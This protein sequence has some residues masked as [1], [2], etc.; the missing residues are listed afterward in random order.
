[1]RGYSPRFTRAIHS[2]KIGWFGSIARARSSSASALSWRFAAKYTRASVRRHLALP[3]ARATACLASLLAFRGSPP[4]SRG[5]LSRQRNVVFDLLVARLNHALLIAALQLLSRARRLAH[6]GR[7]LR[8][9]GR[10]RGMSEL[11]GECAAPRVRIARRS[12]RGGT[13]LV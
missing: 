11:S 13:E 2:F 3:G 6:G 8:A 7:R 9:A 10:H 5:G 4:A 1:M 12:R